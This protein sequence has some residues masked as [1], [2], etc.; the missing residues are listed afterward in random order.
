VQ[1]GKLAVGLPKQPKAGA[2]IVGCVRK[3]DQDKDHLVHGPFELYVLC[4][5]LQEGIGNALVDTGSQISLVKEDVLTRGSLAECDISQI[6]GITGNFMALK[7]RT[8]LNIGDTS[9]HDFLVVDKLPMT[10]DILLG[11]DWLERFGF[12]LQIPSLGITL[13]AYS[14][15]LV[16]VPT[17]EKGNRL[18]ENQEL[19]DNIFCASSVVECKDNTFLCLVV[20]LNSTEQKL[21]CF[22]QT[23][24][25]PKLSG[26]FRT[27]EQRESKKRNQKLQDQLRLTHVKDG[28]GEIRQICAEYVDVFKL[29]GDKLTVTSG[30]E[31][32]IPT[33]SIPAHRAITLR[34]YRIPEKHQE[35]VDEQVKQMLNEGIIQPSKSAWNFPILVVAKKLDASGKRKWRICIDF[36]KLNDVTVGDSF[37]IPNIQDI[38]DKLGRARYFSALDCASG[39]LQVPLAEEDRPKTAFSTSSFHYEYLRMPYGLKSAPSTFQRLMN[40]VLM[41]LIGTRCFVYLDDIIIFG[42]TLEDHH[43]RLR[44]VLDRLRQ[45]NLKIEPDKCEFLKTELTYLG[46]VVTGEGVKPD[47]QKVHAISN[48]PTPKNRTDVK[49][50][51]G[52]AGYYRRFIPHFSKIAKPLNDLQKKDQ[53]WKWEQ[54]QIQSF[55]QLQS[56]LTEEPVL[57]YPDFTKP[58]IVTTDAS[59]FA[60]GAILSQGKVGED[61]PIAYASRTLSDSEQNYSTIE[62]ELISIIWACKHFR[63]YLLGRNFTIVTDH[64]PLTWM[65]NVKDPSSRL[66]RWRLLLEEYNYTISYKAGKRNVN[67]DA[68]SR[69]PVVM[70]V[71]I[72]SKEKQNKILKEMHECPVG[73]H[74]GVQRTYERLKLY[75]TWPG[76]FKHVENYVKHCA[77]CQKNKFTGPY[78]QS[79]FQETDTQFYAWNKIY[80]DIVGPLHLTEGGYKYILTCQDN[81]SKYLIAAPMLTQ[82]AEEVTLTFLRH[83]VLLYGIPQDIVTDQGSQFMG[84]IFTRLC[85]VLKLKKLNTTAYRPQSNAALERAHKSLVEYLRCFCNPRGDDWEKW[86]PFACFVYNTTPHTMTKFT[87]Y[88][89]LFGRKANIP[90]SL[91]QRSR[92]SYNYDD[93]IHD[94]KKKLQDC[95]EVARR[96]LIQTKQKRIEKQRDKVNM[97]LLQEGDL[98]LLRNEKCSKLDPLWLGPFK[99]TEVDNKGSN[100]TIELSKRKR[101]KVHVNRLKVYL[102]NEEMEG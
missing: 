56:I 100:V 20:N 44:E 102:S 53:Q 52:L 78:I 62:R 88:E 57:Q 81:L 45:Y 32:H 67:A 49:S 6:Q 74:Q 14:E 2:P 28:E 50:F 80:L 48:F 83:I 82:T 68:L 84:D 79:P 96:N 17:K 9:L 5:Q 46:H 90:G 86:L 60:I 36:R 92:P 69:N 70:T 38:L 54:E 98:V 55:Q 63:P 59:G 58:F 31:H 47:P 13:P 87:P 37:P 39:Y 29:P 19:Q 89:L 64:K 77:I 15:T 66:L 27:I 34:N 12:N 85:K 101:Q 10:Y 23:E 72:A 97:P 26:T 41:G 35:E 61:K 51:L 42:E 4:E 25:L 99:I 40:N 43:I 8:Q 71:M 76:M 7:G 91:Q 11:Q 24:P 93:I 75:V 94:V 73:G 3:S 18:V 65:F 22:P 95:H 21:K 16:R 30:I 33:P 1:T